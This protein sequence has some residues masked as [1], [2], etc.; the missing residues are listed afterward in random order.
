MMKC[1]YHIPLMLDVPTTGTALVKMDFQTI[2]VQNH[3]NGDTQSGETRANRQ[4]NQHT[5]TGE[6]QL[7]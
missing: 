1:G 2:S 5:R 3:R 7:N 4:L 6:T